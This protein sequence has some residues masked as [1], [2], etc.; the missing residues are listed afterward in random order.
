MIA[1]MEPAALSAAEAS[2]TSEGINAASVTCDVGDKAAVDAAVA[3]AVER[4][5]SLDIA[6]ANAGIVRSAAFLDLSEADWDDVLRVN[7]KGVF[8]TG[9]AAARQMVAQGGGGA[10]VNLSSVNA[11]TAIPT[12]ASYNA[13]KGGINNLTRNMA[14][15]LAGNQIRVNAVAPGR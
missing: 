6:V 10:I 3:A 13:S 11:I 1:D 8:L 4:F 9:Q 2:L 14:L 12:I 5:G 15:S 7:L